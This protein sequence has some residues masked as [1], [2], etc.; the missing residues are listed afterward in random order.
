MVPLAAEPI[1]HIGTFPVTNALINGWIAVIFFLI[2]G[3]LIRGH[4]TLI[5]GKLQNF[6]ESTLEWL[7]GYCDQ[8]TGSRV[9]T[10]R[11]LPIVASLFLFILFSNWVGLLPGTGS[12][13]RWEFLEGKMELVPLLRPIGSD[14]NTTLAL[15]V[16]AVTISHFFGII[17]IGFFKHAN[18]FIQLGTLWKS[19]RKGG[20]SI[21]VAV[22]EM[23]VGLIEIVGEI[24]K[25]I[26]LSLRLFGNVFAG[27]VLLTVMAGL[28]P[29]IVPTPFM[30]LEVLVGIIQ[31]GIFAILTLVYLTVATT[32][33]A[34]EE[35]H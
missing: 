14:L 23:G 1:F 30:L 34:E 32:D 31:A 9:K 21:F 28:I 20:I 2:L 6:I 19:L 16:F 15:A 12:I 11:L 26:S 29:F 33:H 8:V 35:A 13:G 25:V 5:P 3:I 27:E 24:A 4:A 10:E 17:T 7:M 18:K 22:I